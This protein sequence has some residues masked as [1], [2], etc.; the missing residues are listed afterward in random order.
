VRAVVS[1]LGALDDRWKI[2]RVGQVGFGD[3][4]LSRPRF[5]TTRSFR[6]RKPYHATAHA[7][8]TPLLSVAMAAAVEL[9]LSQEWLSTDVEGRLG[10]PTVCGEAAAP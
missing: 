1:G 10:V 9:G 4:S 7:Q 5:G 3:E 6:E 8:T 2:G